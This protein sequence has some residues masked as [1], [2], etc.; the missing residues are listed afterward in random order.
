MV[1]SKSR[2]D[3]APVGDEPALG[4]SYSIT[5]DDKHSIVMQTFLP[6]RC[7]LT[8]LDEVLDKTRVAVERQA[9]I[10]MIPQLRKSLKLQQKQFQRV[11]QDLAFQDELNQ[12]AF[13]AAGK[14]GIF[15]L[16]NEQT[17]HRANVLVTQTRFKE[18]IADIER[19]LADLEA[20]INATHSSSGS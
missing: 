6:R 11:T 2:V 8:E 13:K 1:A 12:T 9:N 16:S 5:I 10:R 15:R 20:A 18:E 19:E 7:S 17:Q 4:F 14:K 3:T